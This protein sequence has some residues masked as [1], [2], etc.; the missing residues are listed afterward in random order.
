MRWAKYFFF[1]FLLVSIAGCSTNPPVPEATVQATPEDQSYQK[2]V[3]GSIVS[4]KTIADELLIVLWQAQ[5]N[6]ALLRNQGWVSNARSVLDDFSRETSL[7]STYS[8]PSSQEELGIK[9]RL[10]EGY[11]ASFVRNFGDFLGTRNIRSL[12]SSAQ[13]LENFE[14]IL[15]LLLKDLET[16][17]LQF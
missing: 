5:S 11:L 10:L 15:D 17:D 16:E 14:R 8:A 3:H 12:Q 7:L 6:P 2:N 13:D 1:V 9:V 4:I